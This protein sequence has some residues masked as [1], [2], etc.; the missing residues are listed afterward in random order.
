MQERIKELEVQIEAAR[1]NAFTSE[2]TPSW[3]VLFKT[4]QAATMAASTRIYA[5]D[6]TEFQVGA[7]A[8]SATSSRNSSR[9]C[10]HGLHTQVRQQRVALNSQLLL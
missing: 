2:F 7:T 1:R 3:F 8:M 5:E 4:Q 6:S 10:M 9:V